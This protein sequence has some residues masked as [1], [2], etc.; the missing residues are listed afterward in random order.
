MTLALSTVQIRKHDYSGNLN[1]LN[2]IVGMVT[3]VD[4]KP[5]FVINSNAV[6]LFI[7]LSFSIFSEFSYAYKDHN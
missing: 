4:I 3:F 5:F 2:S 7:N 6:S 1:F